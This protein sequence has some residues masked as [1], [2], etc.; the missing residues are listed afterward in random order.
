MIDWADICKSLF[1]ET[2]A[3]LLQTDKQATNHDEILFIVF[4]YADYLR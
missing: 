4:D 2:S 1:H 3:D